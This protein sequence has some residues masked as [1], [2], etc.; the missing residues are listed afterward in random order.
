[1]IYIAKSTKSSLDHFA[2]TSPRLVFVEVS[3]QVLLCDV[4]AMWLKLIADWLVSLPGMTGSS[5][6]VYARPL[7]LRTM[8][9]ETDTFG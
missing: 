7:N 5:A 2:K 4:L 3:G 8:E 6:I 9:E 1:M